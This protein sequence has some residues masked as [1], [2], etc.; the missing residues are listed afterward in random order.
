MHEG[1]IF[2]KLSEE[3]EII[4]YKRISESNC[5]KRYCQSVDLPKEQGAMLAA[6]QTKRRNPKL[7]YCTETFRY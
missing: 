5:T 1:S 3:L 4:A 7:K 2:S 6:S